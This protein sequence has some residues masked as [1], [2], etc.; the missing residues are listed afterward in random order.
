MSGCYLWC[1]KIR[2][3]SL[4]CHVRHSHFP[5]G[6]HVNMVYLYLYTFAI[7]VPYKSTKWK[8]I[9]IGAALNPAGVGNSS[10]HVY[11]G[12]SDINLH[13][14]HWFS[15]ILA[16]PKQTIYTH[17][18]VITCIWHMI[19]SITIPITSNQSH[20]P[21]GSIPVPLSKSY[22]VDCPFLR[23]KAVTG[24][25]PQIHSMV[26]TQRYVAPEVLHRGEATSRAYD[27]RV[28][29]R[30]KVFFWEVW[31]ILKWMFLWY[32]D[33][34]RFIGDVRTGL[35]ISTPF[36]PEGPEGLNYMMTNLR[37]SVFEVAFCLKIWNCRDGLMNMCKR[38][39]L[40]AYTLFHPRNY[41]DGMRQRLCWS[42]RFG[43]RFT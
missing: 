22:S 8:Y 16:G 18:S 3:F 32:D 33:M 30:C 38:E 28:A 6:T 23:S 9:Y 27:F 12:H 34:I 35:I 20:L 11:E 41:V 42:R 1:H 2:V 29:S 40:L 26:G 15:S 25:L 17:M 5:T 36:S 43:E 19:I 14:I 10:I 39:V 24:S 37:T 31:G 13:G 21:N 7:H 4:F